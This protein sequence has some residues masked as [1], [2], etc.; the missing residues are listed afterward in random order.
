[1]VKRT[2][3]VLALLASVGLACGNEPSRV[4]EPN[5]EVAGNAPDTIDSIVSFNQI[6]VYQGV[7]VTLLDGGQVT[8]PNAP[9]VPGRP[10]LVRVHAKTAP[11]PAGTS[12]PRKPIRL[13]AELRVHVDGEKDIVLTDG[14]R[15]LTPTLD[16][17]TITSTFNFELEPEQVKPGAT[18]SVELFDPTGKD[19][20]TVRYPATEEEPALPMNV[21]PIAPKLKVRLVPVQYEAD[22]SGRMPPLDDAT[23]EAYRKGLYKLYPAA[24]VEVSVRE[25]LNW[26]LVVEPTGKGWDELLDAIMK[27]RKSDA[28]PDDVYYVGIFNPAPT[29]GEY[30]KRGCVLGVA[31]WSALRETSLRAALVVGYPSERANGTMAQEI[32]HAMGRAHAPCGNPAGIDRK[33]PYTSGGIGVWGWDIIDK[34]LIDPEGRVF[35]FMSYCSPVWVSDYTFKALYERMVEDAEAAAAAG[36]GGQER[37]SAKAYRVAEDG[38]LRPGPTID[39]PA[40]SFADETFVLEDASHAV[41]GQIRGFFRPTSGIGGGYLVVPDD[42][43]AA[44]LKRARFAR[45]ITLQK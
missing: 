3:P 28:P 24:D 19:P 30:C 8:E 26:P 4:P 38:S 34:E 45:A 33:Y 12:M 21:G 6:A 36:A 16:E 42:A 18:L 2:A 11:P 15:T 14:P 27:T 25:P 22:G 39:V 43:P 44:A 35:D 1:M 10:A 31:P 20:T 23:V 32:A 17:A 29:E 41:V 13:K 40:S 37:R 7:K 9:V 5:V